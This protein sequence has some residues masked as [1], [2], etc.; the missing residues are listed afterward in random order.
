[1][2]ATEAAATTLADRLTFA[3]EVVPPEGW[4]V[5]EWVEDELLL[6]IPL[7]PRHPMAAD[8]D[9]DMIAYLGNAGETTTEAV[10]VRA[11]PFAALAR[12]RRD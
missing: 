1:M 6:A 10:A 7:V 9:R 4:D 3:V 11:H 12:L 8:C 2:V 5:R